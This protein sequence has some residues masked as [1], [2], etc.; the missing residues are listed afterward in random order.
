MVPI[1]TKEVVYETLQLPTG[2]LAQVN[3]YH[4]LLFKNSFGRG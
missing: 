2:Q 1:A 4:H 3:N